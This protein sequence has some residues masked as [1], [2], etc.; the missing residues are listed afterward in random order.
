M[1]QNATIPTP[2][3]V[4]SL[5]VNT[6]KTRHHGFTLIELM[7]V[8]AIIAVLALMAVPSMQGKYIRENIAEAMP[9]AKIAKDPVAAAWAATKT[10][11]DDNTS[12]GLPAPDKMVNNVVKS[13]TV[14]GGAIHIVFGNRVNGALRGKT[15]TLRPAVVEDAPIVPVA[16]VCGHAKAPDKMTTLGTDKTD[17]PTAHL[18]VNCL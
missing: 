17:I 12:A 16:W 4:V 14:E 15:L 9:L 10:M 1:P 11:P 2:A 6:S 18:P 13:V 5:Q 8:V 7:V 3:L